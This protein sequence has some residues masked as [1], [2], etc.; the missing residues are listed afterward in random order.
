LTLLL[1]VQTFLASRWL[2]RL[3]D[4]ILL[5]NCLAVSFAFLMSVCVRKPGIYGYDELAVHGGNCATYAPDCEWQTSQWYYVGCSEWETWQN[6]DDGVSLFFHP[7]GMSG[8]LNSAA[9]TLHS[10]EG[11]VLITVLIS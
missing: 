7:Y 1:S 6:T 10:I 11:V 4:I 9:N 8:D 2:P 5:R 3:G